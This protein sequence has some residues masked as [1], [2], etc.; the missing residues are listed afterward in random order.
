MKSQKAFLLC[1]INQEDSVD[2]YRIVFFS[3]Y[4][5]IVTSAF[6]FLVKKLYN[7]LQMFP[8]KVKNTFHPLGKK[9]KANFHFCSV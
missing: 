1:G 7:G 3:A 9:R 6:L 8:I 5:L 2:F 4:I